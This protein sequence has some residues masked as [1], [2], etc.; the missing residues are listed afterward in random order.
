M[1]ESLIKNKLL[2]RQKNGIDDFNREICEMDQQLIDSKSN[3]IASLIILWWW[4]SNPDHDNIWNTLRPCSDIRLAP[5]LTLAYTDNYYTSSEFQI[6][7]F[8]GNMM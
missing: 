6:P 1:Q 8:A 5:F 2:E 4:S 3:L 7:V